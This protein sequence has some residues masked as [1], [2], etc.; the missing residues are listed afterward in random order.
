M[1]DSGERTEFSTGAVRDTAEG[2]PRMNLISPFFLERLALWSGLGAKKYSDRNWEAGMPMDRVVDSLLRHLN[3]YR[4]GDR[5]ED[6]LAAVA[7]NCEVLIHYEEMIK[8]GKMPATLNNI[9]NYKEQPD[10]PAM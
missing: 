5:T 8:L 10:V 2:K 3:M 4:I 6:H 9:P 7:W 1:H